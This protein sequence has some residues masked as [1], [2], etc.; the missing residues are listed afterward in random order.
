MT[1][2]IGFAVAIGAEFLAESGFSLIDWEA[3]WAESSMAIAI[4]MIIAA[5]IAIGVLL[6]L[7]KNS[8]KNT[9]EKVV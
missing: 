9:S 2:L 5:V 8:E 3:G 4:G 6:V 7:K 1:S